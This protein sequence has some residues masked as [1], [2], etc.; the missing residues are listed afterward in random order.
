M[1]MSGR[2]INSIFRLLLN[3]LKY[4]GINIITPA[5]YTEIVQQKYVYVYIRV[6]VCVYI[7]NTIVA[8]GKT[9]KPR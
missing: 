5:I 4:L 2:R 8:N 9:V 3:I 1:E 7:K 6:C